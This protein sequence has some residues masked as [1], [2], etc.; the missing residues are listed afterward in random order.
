MKILPACA[1]ARRYIEQH[2]RGA[3]RSERALRVHLRGCSR[4]RGYY[5]RR[6]LVEHLDP[7]AL[8]AERRLAVG[9]G[10]APPASRGRSYLWAP[11][12]AATLL[13]LLLLPRFQSPTGF[14]ARG[15]AIERPGPA[16]WV[17]RVSPS[18]KG[19]PVHQDIRRADE[20]AFGY[21]APTDTGFL[22]VFGRDE[23][24]HVYWYHPEWTDATGDP[25]SI[26]I[27]ADPSRHELPA[28]I[29]HELDGKELELCDVFSRSPFRAR[30]IERRLEQAPTHV[31]ER[32]EG[33]HMHCRT[34]RV[35]P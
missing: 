35:S 26:S 34:L 19:E 11:L 17:Y 24:G 23:H 9:L 13:L 3:S 16:L 12:A 7:A 15:G 20:L 30:D 31:L 21:R 4:C 32:L 14:R 25:V 28:A 5:D 33:V 1:A 22:L 8:G 27:S 18:G 6:L 29:S 2:F 10:F